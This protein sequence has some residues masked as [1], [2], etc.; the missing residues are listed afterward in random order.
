MKTKVYIDGQAGTTGLQIYERIGMREDL[1]LLRIDEDKRHDL[2]ERKKFLNM[3]D[4][5]FLCLPDAGAVEAVSL[6]ENPDVR[7]IDASTAH[8]TSDQW[9]YGFPEISREQRAAIAASKRVAN[10]GCHATGLI[11]SVAPLIRMG[12]LPKDYPVTCYSLTGYSGGG[13]KMIAQ[14]EAE[15]RDE[16]LSAPG[17]YGLTLKHKHIPEMQKVTGLVNPPV[18]MPVVDDYYKGMATSVMLQNRLLNGQPT[19]EEICLRLQEY[20]AGEHFVTV[21][22]Y[23]PKQGT[24]YANAL[25]GTNHLQLVVCGYEEQTTVTALFDN[26]GK[27]ASGAAV[28][29]MNIMLGLPEMT[30]LE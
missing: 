12:I 19:A 27:G 15:D 26:L 7:V 1:T 5:V 30:G 9:T 22:P 10:P 6:I 28:Q 8:R 23:D 18:F 16:K 2:A 24:L 14:Y 21:M 17:I 20:Y 11:S 4:I 29:N 13:K 25:A 3:A